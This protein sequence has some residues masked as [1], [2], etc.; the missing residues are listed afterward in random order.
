MD[1][2]KI[3]SILVPGEKYTLTALTDFGFPYRQHMTILEVSVTPYA[4]YKE[5]L[6]IR[7]KR[8]RGRKVLSVRFYAQH[9]EFVIWKGHVSPKTELYGEPVQVDSGLIVRQGRYRPFH[10]G[11]LRDAIASVIEQ[12][13]LTF[14]IN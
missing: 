7:F 10:Q 2:K 12:P 1:Y 14:G 9:E 13:L 3:A 4:Q 6:L 5:S 8:P 11:Y